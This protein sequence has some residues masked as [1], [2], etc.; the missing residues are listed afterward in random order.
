[1]KYALKNLVDDSRDIVNL[2][3]IRQVGAAQSFLRVIE[4]IRDK[5]RDDNES[6]PRISDEILN[7]FRFKAGA[8]W[9]LNEILSVPGEAE[10]LIVTIEETEP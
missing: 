9:A 2:N 3:G 6:R 4:R 10:K 5:I 8:I 7:D 1:M